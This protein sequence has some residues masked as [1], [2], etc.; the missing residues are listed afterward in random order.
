VA[1]SQ[2][3]VSVTLDRMPDGGIHGPSFEALVD[4]LKQLG[5]VEVEHPCAVVSIVGRRIRAVLHD[6]GPALEVLGD[7]PVHLVSD[8]SE[9]LNLSL[10]VGEADGASLVARLHERLFPAQGEEGRLGPTWEQ[11][12]HLRRTAHD[13]GSG[14]RTRRPDG[15]RDHPLGTDRVGGPGESR[16]KG[17]WWRAERAR[18]LDSVT[19]GEARYVY[20]LPTV[21]A[22]ARRL[23]ETLGSVDR[24]YYSMKANAHPD[25]LRTVANAGLGIECVSAAEIETVRRILGEECPILFTP[26]FCPVDE[27]ETALAAGADVTLD[28]YELLQLHAPIFRGHAVGVRVDPGR[29]LGHHQHVRT[30][31]S[32]SKFGMPMPEIGAFVEAAHRAGARVTGIHAHV[33]SGIFDPQAW[34]QTGQLLAEAA[35]RIP[36]LE[37]M[38]LGGGLGVPERPGQEP[39]DL[40]AMEPLLSKLRSRLPGC[41]LRLEPGRYLVSEAGVLVA[42]V[43]Q[44]R[45]KNGTNLVGIA[46]GMN[47]LIRPALY[48]AW[49]GIHNLTRLDEGPVDYWNIVGPI[50]ESSDVLGRDRWL[51]PMKVGDVVLIEN[52]GAYGAVMSSRY[53]QRPPAA[54]IVLD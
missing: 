23:R 47:S 48:G 17:T 4:R 53:N 33:G 22:A 40:E 34:A 9:D 25:V 18:L 52:A 30:A 31:G 41:R 5:T 21:A 24:F 11:I 20:H 35:E 19:D 49:H 54:E 13:D 3:A 45:R 27:Y 51:P 8:S 38:D 32:R 1:T 36:S 29:G 16:A 37:W 15:D 43:T 26:N 10:V 44:V 50:C 28:G 6:L 42:P 7:R 12:V 2:S 39:L 46:T 14:P